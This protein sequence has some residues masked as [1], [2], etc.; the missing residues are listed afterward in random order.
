MS[1]LAPN[2]NRASE[3]IQYG[4]GGGVWAGS[5]DHGLEIARQI[6][7]GYLVVNGAMASYEAPFGGYKVSGIG[8]EFGT[9]GLSA[10][11]ELKGVN[12]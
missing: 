10:Y 3:T 8:R 1:H 9:A 4:L 5:R 6:R 2:N 11:L 12:L 7:S